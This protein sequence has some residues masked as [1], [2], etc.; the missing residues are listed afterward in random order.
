MNK[1]WEE[2][3]IEQNSKFLKERTRAQAKASPQGCPPA[4]H[5]LPRAAL[6]AGHSGCKGKHHFSTQV[7][8]SVIST[9][10]SEM[11][12]SKAASIQETVH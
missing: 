10:G 1:T 4:E 11:N 9:E 2:I 8:F 3:S 12:A 6:I 7:D 5:H